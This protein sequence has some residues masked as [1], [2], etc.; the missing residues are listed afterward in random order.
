MGNAERND[1]TDPL[2]FHTGDRLRKARELRGMDMT[3]LANEIGQTRK[4]VA[5]YEHWIDLKAPRESTLRQWSMATGVSLHW[6]KTGE[7][8]PGEGPLAQLV[9]LRTFNPK[10]ARRLRLISSLKRTPSPVRLSGR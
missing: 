4:T 10:S 8:L 3:Q 6:L 7:Y 5:A 9:E 2:A 1:E